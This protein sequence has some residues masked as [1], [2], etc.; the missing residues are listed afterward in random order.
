MDGICPSG[1][2]MLKIKNTKLSMKNNK[3]AKARLRGPRP[4]CF[5]GPFIGWR[6]W[7]NGAAALCQPNRG[8]ICKNANNAKIRAMKACLMRGAPNFSQA[9]GASRF[10][11]IQ[12]T[13]SH[14]STQ[15]Y[16][17]FQKAPPFFPSVSICGCCLSL[18]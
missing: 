17:D 5:D 11:N 18:D 12:K 14:R 16:T 15:T 13:F 1:C 6:P 8:K 9:A 3:T 2:A 10:L 7:P 4:V